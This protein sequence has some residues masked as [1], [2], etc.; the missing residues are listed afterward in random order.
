[1]EFESDLIVGLAL[2]AVAY[3][4]LLWAVI[5]GKHVVEEIARGERSDRPIPPEDGDETRGPAEEPGR[6]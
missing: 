4:F 6:E 2:T 5:H 1:M 3:G